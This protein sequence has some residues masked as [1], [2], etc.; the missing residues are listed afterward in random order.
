MKFQKSKNIFIS[1]LVTETE[2]ILTQGYKIHLKEFQFLASVDVIEFHTVKTYSRSGLVGV[3]YNANQL[4][5]L[6]NK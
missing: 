6:E 3:K 1:K 5:K 4:S 2:I